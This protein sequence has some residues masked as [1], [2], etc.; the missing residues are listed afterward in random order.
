MCCVTFWWTKMFAKW[1]RQTS[2]TVIAFA[3]ILMLTRP[4]VY[5]LSI[6]K[7]A[8]QILDCDPNH[9]LELE[10]SVVAHEAT[11]IGIPRKND[12]TWYL[13]WSEP[14]MMDFAEVGYCSRVCHSD[15]EFVSIQRP[16][17]TTSVI[18]IKG[19]VRN[20]GLSGISCR[21]YN[22]KTKQQKFYNCSIT[23]RQTMVPKLEGEGIDE[24]GTTSPDDL[25]KK[26]AAKI[27]EKGIDEEGTISPD[28]L[29]KKGAAKMEEKGI[30]QEG[31]ISPDDL[32][33]KEIYT[34]RTN[35]SGAPELEEE[36]ADEGGTTSTDDLLKKAWTLQKTVG[37]SVVIRPHDSNTEGTCS[38]DP[39]RL[40]TSM[41]TKWIFFLMTTIP[42]LLCT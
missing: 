41:S 1:Q 8:F 39:C 16:T 11:C 30:D 9:P 5:C 35:D 21:D 33:K 3:I 26:R 27:Q 25:F 6:Q 17:K 4:S 37:A 29:I 28:D 42:K 2:A 12:V 40:M 14:Y 15:W 20:L 13:K 32:L 34:K 22:R 10:R 19:R 18:R 38:M 31:T 23:V 24:E 36:G 7:P